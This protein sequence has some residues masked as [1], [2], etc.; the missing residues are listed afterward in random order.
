MTTEYN[1]VGGKEN[2]EKSYNWMTNDSH[3]FGGLLYCSASLLMAHEILM[4]SVCSFVF[5]PVRRPA[6]DSWPKRSSILC[7]WY[8]LSELDDRLIDRLSA[9]YSPEFLN[10]L[11]IQKQSF[12]HTPPCGL[13]IVTYV[14]EESVVSIFRVSEAQ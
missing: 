3:Y 10:F 14:S 13:L 4:Y 1:K 7:W 8:L 12:S 5:V 2:E 11:D 6:C 9:L